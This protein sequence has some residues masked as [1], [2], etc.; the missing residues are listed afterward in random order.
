MLQA[1]SPGGNSGPCSY[2][3]CLE[4]EHPPVCCLQ[5]EHVGLLTVVR[6]P[7]GQSVVHTDG[8]LQVPLRQSLVKPVLILSGVC[9]VTL[10]YSS[11]PHTAHFPPSLLHIANTL[12]QHRITT[13]ALS[14]FP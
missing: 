9:Y 6:S 10:G 7:G 3:R 1:G 5:L 13:D 4:E 8:I 14:T 2:L 11:L 12:S